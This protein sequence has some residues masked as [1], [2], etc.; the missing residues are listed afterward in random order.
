[1][2]HTEFN[3]RAQMRSECR[4]EA[5][6]REGAGR[7]AGWQT[8]EDEC[9]IL[10]DEGTLSSYRPRQGWHTRWCEINVQNN[11][12]VSSQGDAEFDTCSFFFVRRKAYGAFHL[13]NL[14]GKMPS[15][16]RCPNTPAVRHM[17]SPQI[18]IVC[19]L[20]LL[21]WADLTWCF[22]HFVIHELYML[23]MCKPQAYIN[24]HT[25]FLQMIKSLFFLQDI[26]IKIVLRRNPSQIW[27]E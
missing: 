16:K 23:R 5:G 10:I 15:A 2:C 3:T 13:Q 1:M 18:H 8:Y 17:G 9:G 4:C 20:N 19:I 14:W 25:D 11:N 22:F 6:R 7:R 12:K 26:I 24:G 21:V 27:F